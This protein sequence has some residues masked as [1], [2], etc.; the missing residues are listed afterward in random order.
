MNISKTSN[1][2]GRRAVEG[3]VH[4]YVVPDDVHDWIKQHGGSRYVTDTFRA[5]KAATLKAQE[6]KQKIEEK[7]EDSPDSSPSVQASDFKQVIKHICIPVTDEPIEEQDCKLICNV[8][9][10]RYDYPLN[11]DSGDGGKWVM[12]EDVDVTTLHKLVEIIRECLESD[13]DQGLCSG[14]PHRF[15]DYVIEGIEICK[16][17][18][19]ATV[20]FGS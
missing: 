20:T 14:T 2:R 18:R 4:K 7:K 3:S 11:S 16:D 19:V 9:R 12:D 17:T 5:I 1:K 6:Q 13:Y 10:I 15:E 8:K